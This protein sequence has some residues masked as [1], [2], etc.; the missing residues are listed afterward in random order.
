MHRSRSDISLFLFVRKSSA[1]TPARERIR[2]DFVFV[3]LIIWHQRMKLNQ[4]Y[5]NFMQQMWFWKIVDFSLIS[6][7]VPQKIE[8]LTHFYK[9][10]CR[11][12]KC[13]YVLQK[14]LVLIKYLL[15]LPQKQSCVID[16]SENVMFVR[17][18][19]SRRNQ[20]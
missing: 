7:D 9:S 10:Q 11:T 1:S 20:L 19:F 17:S 3:S 8:D 18:Q 5:M 12:F 16:L 15:Q 2:F 13:F 14:D 6:K 4:I